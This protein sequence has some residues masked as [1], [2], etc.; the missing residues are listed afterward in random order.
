[1]GTTERRQTVPSSI[2]CSANVLSSPALQNR[3]ASGEGRVSPGAEQ[4]IDGPRLIKKGSCRNET[5]LQCLAFDDA[6]HEAVEKCDGSWTN[7]TNW[8]YKNIF[9]WVPTSNQLTFPSSVVPPPVP[10]S[11]CPFIRDREPAAPSAVQLPGL[12]NCPLVFYHHGNASAPPFHT[13]NLPAVLPSDTNCSVPVP[14]GSLALPLTPS[15]FPGLSTVPAQ[16]QRES[17][18]RTSSMTP[19]PLSVNSPPPSEIASSAASLTQVSTIPQSFA[20]VPMFPPYV[21]PPSSSSVPPYVY[22]QPNYCFYYQTTPPTQRPMF[23]PHIV[24]SKA[25]SAPLP[26]NISEGSLAGP[27]DGSSHSSLSPRCNSQVVTRGAQAH[28]GEPSYPQIA[29]ESSSCLPE[30]LLPNHGCLRTGSYPSP[31]PAFST[32]PASVSTYE[33]VVPSPN[34]HHSAC[35]TNTAKLPQQGVGRRGQRGQR[36]F[37]SRSSMSPPADGLS[38]PHSSGGGGSPSGNSSIDWGYQDGSSPLD[39]GRFSSDT[40]ESK[41]I[42]GRGRGAKGGIGRTVSSRNRG[43]GGFRG[44]KGHVLSP[45]LRYSHIP[46]NEER[47]M[48]YYGDMRSIFIKDCPEYWNDQQIHSMLLSQLNG[49]R[50]LKITR[51]APLSD[52]GESR[53]RLWME[54]DSV[55]TAMHMISNG[56]QLDKRVKVFP[57][58]PQDVHSNPPPLVT[59]LVNH[60]HHSIPGPHPHHLA[61]APVAPGNHP[62]PPPPLPSHQYTGYRLQHLGPPPSHPGSI[63]NR[64]MP[65][66]SPGHTWSGSVSPHGHV[67][68]QAVPHPPPP[69]PLPSPHCPVL[70]F[71]P[72]YPP[73][74]ESAFPGSNDAAEPPHLPS[75]TPLSSTPPVRQSPP[76]KGLQS[77]PATCQAAMVGNERPVLPPPL[78]SLS[79]EMG[80]PTSPPLSKPGRSANQP[81]AP[82]P[83]SNYHTKQLNGREQY[84]VLCLEGLRAAVSEERISFIAT[85]FGEIA[86][87][88]CSVDQNQ[89]RSCSIEFQEC[90]CAASMNRYFA[91]PENMEVVSNLWEDPHFPQMQLL[92]CTSSKQSPG[93]PVSTSLSVTTSST[94]P[95]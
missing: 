83:P 39:Q 46:R 21:Q 49:G 1:M 12:S 27:P 76:R 20:S 40:P 75:N 15:H 61:A 10:P 19:I 74:S 55:P 5:I 9:Y 91:M 65:G 45:R 82:R 7:T 88:H 80:N 25:P 28:D 35:R 87:V 94:M 70:P 79:A 56:V 95:S 34:S 68:S 54:L 18:T 81:P 41:R 6:S 22:Y 32:S 58:S 17:A 47:D 26:T 13:E 69:Y 64:Q 30:H 57:Y 4:F 66:A 23:Q 29:T 14:G 16:W 89:R 31:A 71:H 67:A 86:G 62:P 42:S 73:A 43:G 85:Q 50:I 93:T 84:K 77:L 11:L 3:E 44:A 38:T 53:Q 63:D 48:R 2:S 92:V 90:G 33:S 59:P 60:A 36:E 78:T 24:S 37:L 51:M 8:S 52:D 72:R